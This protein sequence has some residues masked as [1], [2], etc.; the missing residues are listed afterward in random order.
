M[1]K[2]FGPVVQQ[3]YIVSDIDE[4]MQYW[5]ARGIGPFYN[6]KHISP[7]CGINIHTTIAVRFVFKFNRY[8]APFRLPQLNPVL[9]RHG[10]NLTPKIR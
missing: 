2:L 8:M 10:K 9:T 3:Q 5:I 1:S 6:E 4:A 7:S